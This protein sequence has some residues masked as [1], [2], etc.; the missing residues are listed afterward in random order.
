[1]LDASRQLAERNGVSLDPRVL[2]TGFSQGGAAAMGL[3]RAI[4]DGQAGSWR[5][6][7]VAPISGPYDVRTAE[8]PAMLNNQL[9]PESALL[10]IAFWTVSMNRLYHLYQDPTEVFQQPYAATVE[11]MFDG[12]HSEQD[13]LAALPSTPAALLT[14]RYL[15][16]LRH[17]TG[18]L[19]RALRQ[20][21]TSCDWHPDVPVRLFGADGDRDV[22]FTNSE[23]CQAEL[24]AYGDRV[25]LVDVGDVDHN[26]SAE[27]SV[28]LVLEFL[29]EHEHAR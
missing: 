10:Y 8:I 28:P 11:S 7:A 24:A 21:D 5:L 26:T 23:Q 9:D 2:I 25:T 20:N 27:L 18:A 14:P 1:M 3:A 12:S 4:Q 16:E 29:T 6:G 15:A 22:A 17:P 13:I 19:L